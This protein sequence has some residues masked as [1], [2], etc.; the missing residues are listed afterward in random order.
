MKGLSDIARRLA[1]SRRWMEQ[2]VMDKEDR[3]PTN[4]D[5]QRIKMERRLEELLKQT[6]CISL[7]EWSRPIDITCIDFEKKKKNVD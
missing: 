4:P 7:L 6:A 5:E 3:L 1:R 2:T